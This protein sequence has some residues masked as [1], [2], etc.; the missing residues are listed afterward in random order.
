M[1]TLDSILARLQR[2]DSLDR[3]T[4]ITIPASDFQWLCERTLELLQAEPT[5]LDLKAPIW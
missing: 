1:F 2:A 4:P 3:G 5:V